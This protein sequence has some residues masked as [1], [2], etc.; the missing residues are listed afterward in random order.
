MDMVERAQ[1]HIA[2]TEQ[3]KCVKLSSKS[4]ELMQIPLW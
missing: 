3:L 2:E 4:A 1:K